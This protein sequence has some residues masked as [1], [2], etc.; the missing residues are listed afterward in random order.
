MK[1]NK[2]LIAALAIFTITSCVDLDTTPE[3][4]TTTKDQKDEVAKYDPSK[5]D[6]DVNAMYGNLI[7]FGTTSTTTTTYHNDFGYPAACMFLDAT[8]QDV[9]APNTGYNWFSAGLDFSDRVYTSRVNTFL[10]RF[11]YN[12]IKAAN[13][14]ISSLPAD[15]EDPLAKAYLGQGYVNRAFGYFSLIQAWQFNYVGNESKP[16]I[17]I[18]LWDDPVEKTANNP[19]ATVEEVY[20]L[21]LNDLKTGIQ[22]LEGFRRDDNSIVDQRVAYGMRARVNL[23]MQ[24]WADAASDAAKAKTGFSPYSRTAVAKPAF[25]NAANNQSWIWGAIISETNDVVKTGIIN[26]PSHLCSMTGNGYT[27][28][29]G[30]HRMI[31]SALW[32]QIPSTDVRKGWW[33]DD[34]LHSANVNDAVAGDYGFTP[35]TNVKFGAYKDEIG[36]STNASDWPM[37]RV[38]EMI[39]IEAEGLAMSG[40]IAP[41][42]ALLEGFIKANRDPNYTCAAASA[43]AFQDEVWF[44]RRVELWGEGFSYYDIMRLKKPIIR[45]GTNFSEDVQFNIPAEDKILLY[46]I[47]SEEINANNGISEEDNNEAVPAP[48]V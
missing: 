9:V 24:K 15:T 42:K 39:L 28:A 45:K 19:R 35:Y 7:I 29:T 14:L 31:N 34:K 18:I 44:Q 40:Q 37:M 2:L 10:W 21:I 17:P 33:V 13:D 32:A 27:S 5:L 47:P 8:G 16:G 25:N 20:D 12:Q 36:Q 48:T 30:T 4:G 38:E 41:A 23:V 43:T 1:Y 26:W 6:A 11:F 22:L 46:R 3:G